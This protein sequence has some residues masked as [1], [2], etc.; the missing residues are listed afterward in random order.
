MN[1]LSI[2][3]WPLNETIARILDLRVETDVEK[4]VGSESVLP[5]WSDLPVH[6]RLN[7]T[8]GLGGVSNLSNTLNSFKANASFAGAHEEGGL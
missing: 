5:A 6:E 2:A 1:R 8:F 4:I 7:A 3:N